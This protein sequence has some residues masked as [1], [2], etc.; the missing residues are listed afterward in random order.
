[1]RGFRDGRR[2]VLLLGAR[3]LFEYDSHMPRVSGSS[4]PVFSVLIVKIIMTYAVLHRVCCSSSNKIILIKSKLI[5][6]FQAYNILSN[7]V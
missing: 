5:L 3:V 2:A 1:V 4:A 6:S 7:R